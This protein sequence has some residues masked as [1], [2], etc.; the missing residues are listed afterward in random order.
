MNPADLYVTI[1]PPP[2]RIGDTET[3]FRRQR[4]PHLFGAD[5]PEGLR[6]GVSGMSGRCRVGLC[7]PKVREPGSRPALPLYFS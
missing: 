7:L 1:R 2:R 3:S 6:L 5:D 4:G